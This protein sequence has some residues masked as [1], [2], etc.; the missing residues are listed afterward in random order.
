MPSHSVLA[1]ASREWADA[2]FEEATLAILRSSTEAACARAQVHLQREDLNAATTCSRKHLSHAR[3]RVSFL[4]NLFFDLEGRLEPNLAA[5]MCLWNSIYRVCRAW[6]RV[7]PAEARI[8]A[9]H[10]H[11]YN[12]LLKSTRAAGVSV[13]CRRLSFSR[14]CERVRSNTF[15]TLFC[16]A[17]MHSP[18][19][20]PPSP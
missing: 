16:R 6:K 2:H 15:N 17:Y 3:T 5:A 19:F 7:D 20:P 4:A 10:A 8:L 11:V 9:A 1:V 12:Q 18:A 14:A 13:S